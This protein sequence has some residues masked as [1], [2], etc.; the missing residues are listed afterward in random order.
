MTIGSGLLGLAP[1]VPA[2]CRDPLHP[3]WV[4]HPLVLNLSCSGGGARFIGRSRADRPGCQLFT[5]DPA[6]VVNDPAV[7]PLSGGDRRPRGPR[8]LILMAIAAG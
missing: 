2:V 5:T 4:R 3:S 8:S 6:L 1:W 7:G